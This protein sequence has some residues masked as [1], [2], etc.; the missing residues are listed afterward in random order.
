MVKNIHK[1]VCEFHRNVGQNLSVSTN[2]A[3]IYSIMASY[4]NMIKVY[5]I[6]TQFQRL[7]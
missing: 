4:D 3:E 7:F 1:L 5:C 6:V 2:L